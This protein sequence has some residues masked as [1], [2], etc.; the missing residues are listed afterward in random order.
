MSKKIFI[1]LII[2]IGLFAFIIPYTLNN[3]SN[4]QNDLFVV[5]EKIKTYGENKHGISFMQDEAVLRWEFVDDEGKRKEIEVNAFGTM[6]RVDGKVPSTKG[7]VNWQQGF[8]KLE[9]VPGHPEI[10]VAVTPIKVRDG[11]CIY[12]NEVIH[13]GEDSR[14]LAQDTD[15]PTLD[16]SDLEEDVGYLYFK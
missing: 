15:W 2:L 11:V 16:I 10:P 5:M 6:C 4:T 1:P 7:F 8:G 13:G 3:L 9:H 12:E 14:I